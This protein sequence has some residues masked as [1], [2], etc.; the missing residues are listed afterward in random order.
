MFRFLLL[1]LTLVLAHPGVAWTQGKPSAS[2]AEDEVRQASRQYNAA[3]LRA[4]TAA[5]GRFWA[6][7][8]TFV[9]PFGE[10]VTRAQ[11][12]A[13]LR[14]GRTAFDTI[15]PQVREEKI[16]VYDGDVAV[17]T[18][19]LTLGGK[20]SGRAHRGDYQ[21]LV[22]WAKRNGQWQQVTSQVTPVAGH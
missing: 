16:R 5:A 6:P 8:Y 13:N 4:D 10:R 11:R 17:Q 12:I 3:L 19:R 2:A 9:N 14:S 1:S 21:A 18:I 7:E 20:Y 15:G 22:V